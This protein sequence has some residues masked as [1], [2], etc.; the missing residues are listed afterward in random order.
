M[1]STQ[2]EVVDCW[3]LNPC[4]QDPRPT[5]SINMWRML[6]SLED[7]IRYLLPLVLPIATSIK[8]LLDYR[9]V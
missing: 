1:Y 4:Y 5:A 2:S 6:R 8:V 9:L 7:S 3:I